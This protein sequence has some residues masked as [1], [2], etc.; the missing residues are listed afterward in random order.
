[1]VPKYFLEHK[2]PGIE[3]GY[4]Y[5]ECK[6]WEYLRNKGNEVIFPECFNLVD[7][8]SKHESNNSKIEAAMGTDKYSKLK[9]ILRNMRASGIKV[10]NP[11]ICVIS[12]KIFF[13]DVKKGG[14]KIRQPQINF[15]Q[16]C[17]KVGIPFIV[18]HLVAKSD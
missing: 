5:G 18:Y 2:G 3:Q 13:A 12:P 7:E 1:L 11:D 4:H 15:A 14:D 10:E 16:A 9:S 8:T 17:L 6:V